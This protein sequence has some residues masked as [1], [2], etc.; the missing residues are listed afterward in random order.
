VEWTGGTQARQYLQRTTTPHLPGSWADIVTNEPPTASLGA[1]L[2][3]V[4]AT[5]A[6]TYY[7]LR[8]EPR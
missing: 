3:A 5:N 8:V 7:R 4:S 2:D 6:A 1:F